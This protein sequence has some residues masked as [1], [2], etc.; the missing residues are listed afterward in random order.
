M[1]R[2]VMDPIVS[3]R[4]RQ[5]RQRMQVQ[6]LDA[7]LVFFEENR[8]YLS[9]F[10]G[11]D[12]QFDESAGALIISHDDLILA[13]DSRYAAQAEQEAAGYDIICYQKG[14]AAEL[15]GIISKIKPARLGFESRR[16]S[17]DQFLKFKKELDALSHPSEWIPTS[18]M[19]D[20]LRM[21]KD[22][23]EITAIRQALKLA[24]NAFEKTLSLIQ[25]GIS[26]CEVAWEIEKRMRSQGAQR[27]SFPVIAAFDQNSALPHAVAG[28][29]TLR[30]NGIILLDWGAKLNHY[31]SDTTRTF[32][33]FIPDDPFKKIFTIVHDA[34]RKAIESI[35]P[36]VRTRE[37]DA[38][39]RNHIESKGFKEFFGHGLGHGVGLAVHEAPSLCPL[40]ERDMEIQKNMVFTVEP[41][42]YLPGWGG[43]RLEN[44][45]RVTDDGVEILNQLETQMRWHE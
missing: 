26:E 13:T 20:G 41:G 40:V 10:T 14:L 27:I 42:I 7:L 19:V 3:H 25:P 15:P 22:E 44:M 5:L 21:I 39:A 43:V 11:E 18:D 8:Y 36:G 12:T 34:Q 32:F 16:I 23:A 6:H 17:H 38:I 2:D 45:V 24:E 33:F 30:H 29:T 4:I 37:I 31:C 28:K 35:R 1:Q 9:G